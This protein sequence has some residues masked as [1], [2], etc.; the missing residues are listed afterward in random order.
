M[1]IRQLRYFTEIYR[2]GS[3]SLAAE[4]LS[5]TQPALSQQIA[6]LER[7]LKTRLFERS[8]KGMAVT[9]AGE[10][11]APCAA[12][13]LGQVADIELALL[14][15]PTLSEVTFAV[16]ETLAAHFVPGLMGNLK[17]RFPDTRFRVRESNLTEIKSALREGTV[18][19]ALSP[20]IIGDGAYTNRYLL[21][22]EILPAAQSDDALVRRPEWEKMRGRD[23]I[24]FH[25]GSAIRKISDS[26]FHSVDKKFAPRIVMELSS[27]AGAVRCIEAGL[28]IGF[29]S[30][31]SLK[32]GLSA[33]RLPALVRKRRF[34]VTHRRNHEKALP[35]VEAILANAAPGERAPSEGKKT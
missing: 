23:W 26:I 10:M 20:E 33:I 1:E 5:V 30:A 3:I 24:L 12:A 19:F 9:A 18:D 31:L 14:P 35:I 29:I 17:K 16:G 2:T 32:P 22:D 15:N 34:Y 21:E 4:N 6:L 28:G 8:R 13:I 25:S 27:V 11:F 7:E